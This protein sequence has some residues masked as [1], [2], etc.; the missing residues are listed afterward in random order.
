MFKSFFLGS[1]I[2]VVLYLISTNSLP[3]QDRLI[4]YGEARYALDF[5]ERDIELVAIGQR[6]NTDDCEKDSI[7]QKHYQICEHT[8]HCSEIKYECKPTME[9]EYKRMFNQQASS[10]HYIHMQDL[11]DQLQGIILLWGLT[12]QES[13]GFC[14]S[15]VDDFLLKR[16]KDITIRCI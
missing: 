11:R 3:Y 9:S 13:K 2:L 16:D 4:T 12:E 15:M 8:P 6:Y 1:I 14:Q 7:I 10:T 5:P